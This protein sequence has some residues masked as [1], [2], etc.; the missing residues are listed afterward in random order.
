MMT[1]F[2]NLNLFIF[3]AATF[4]WLLRARRLSYTQRLTPVINPDKI[5]RN[6]DLVS[7][8]LPAKNE[9]KNIRECIERLQAQQYLN[10]EIIA[11]NDNSKDETENILRSMGAAYVN[12]PFTPEGWTGKNFAIHTGMQKARGEWL[13]FTDADTRHE[14][15]SIAASL[16]HMKENGLEFLTLLPRCITG[17]WLEDLVQPA[18]MAFLGLWFPMEKVN[19]PASPLF[20]ANGQY[21]FIK[22][23]LYE[24]L[25][26]HEAVKGAFLEDFALAKL[27][28]AAKAKT[29]CALGVSVYG[30]RMY[31]SFDSIWKGWRRI[32]LHA[33]EKNVPVLVQKAASV[34]FFSALPFWA[35]IA[36]AAKGFHASLAV[37]FFCFACF[38][39]M[40]I[41]S[42]KAYQVVKAKHPA[43][44][45]LHPVAALL[46]TCILIDA[47]KVAASGGKTVWR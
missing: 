33:F 41:I 40:N 31:D 11:V 42:W 16:A 22:R 6:G 45:F 13:L 43:Y 14:P 5:I 28:K 9:E 36:L 38:L 27:A 17:T 10:V 32:Y 37:Y 24:K 20:F 7:V 1:T 30:T 19:D 23:S 12:A 44:A 4:V 35:L 8:V 46:A 2:E 47:V 39:L 34:F 25:G 15:S 21:L 29:E 3:A 18:T 26:G